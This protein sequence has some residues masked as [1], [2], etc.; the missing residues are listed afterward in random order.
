MPDND[1]PFDPQTGLLRDGYTLK[2]TRIALQPST[3]T[4]SA[5]TPIIRR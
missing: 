1:N 5:N 3:L 4:L 2:F